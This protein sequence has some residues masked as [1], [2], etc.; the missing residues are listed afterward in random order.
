M[1]IATGRPA[2]YHSDLAAAYEKFITSSVPTFQNVS[3]VQRNERERSCS[4]KSQFCQV[5]LRCKTIPGLI[6]DVQNRKFHR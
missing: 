4:L 5:F 1:P 3:E 2:Q 6:G